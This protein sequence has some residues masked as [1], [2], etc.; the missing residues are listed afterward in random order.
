MVVSVDFTLPISEASVMNLSLHK[1]TC[2]L[3]SLR[4]VFGVE[5]EL[6]LVRLRAIPSEALSAIIA[7]LRAATTSVMLLSFHFFALAFCIALGIAQPAKPATATTI[8]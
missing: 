4:K 7:A 2:A 5:E 8:V 1:S 3:K 6:F